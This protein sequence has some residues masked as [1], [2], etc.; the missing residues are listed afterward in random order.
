MTTYEGGCYC[1]A[2][3][4]AAKGPVQFSMVCHCSI[5]R[6]LQGSAFGA[7][8]SFFGADSFEITKGQDK[9]KEF[10][11]PMSYTRRFCS[12]CGSRVTI[13]F[14]KSEIESPMVGVY[15][16][17]LDELRAGGAAVSDVFE[18]KYHAF[19]ADRLYDISDG[20]PKFVDMAAE[21]GG[22]GKTLDDH[23]QPV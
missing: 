6:S 11:S 19:Y 5:C 16:T 21:F 7:L 9:A 3:R 13:S 22:S 14:E 1:G 18:P 12:D 8:V 15:T 20:K 4:F 17:A 10:L 2:L 23:G